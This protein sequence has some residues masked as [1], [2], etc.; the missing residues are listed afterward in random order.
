M[1]LWHLLFLLT[2]AQMLMGFMQLHSKGQQALTSD[3]GARF[4]KGAVAEAVANKWA[5]YNFDNE[6]RGKLT[7]AS[8]RFLDSYGKP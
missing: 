4:I 5:G 7:D 8:W 3:N 1:Q 6:L 2:Y